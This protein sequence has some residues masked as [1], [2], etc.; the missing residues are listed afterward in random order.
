MAEAKILDAALWEQFEQAARA[1][2][3]DPVALVH[4]YLREC[5]EIWEHTDLDEEI[6]RD[7]QRSGY[8]EDD[9]VE[10]VRQYRREKQALLASNT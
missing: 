4:G 3:E 7:V 1:H 5:V 8:R 2:G 6:R 9:A 10:I